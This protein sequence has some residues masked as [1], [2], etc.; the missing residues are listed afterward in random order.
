MISTLLE[1]NEANLQGMNY[2]E[3][4]NSN[5]YSKPYYFFTQ[6][7]D[8]EGY[9]DTI[10]HINAKFYAND[11][12]ENIDSIYEFSQFK[13]T[14]SDFDNLLIKHEDDVEKYDLRFRFLTTDEVKRINIPIG[15]LRNKW[16]DR[17]EAN[18]YLSSSFR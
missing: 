18:R 1:N 13:G 4:H 8:S 17:A 15:G 2:H 10:V 14:L 16:T 12:F 6:I 7:D 9:N 11:N 3:L 5:N